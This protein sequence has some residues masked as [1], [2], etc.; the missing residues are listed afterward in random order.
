MTFVLKVV[1]RIFEIIMS[2]ENYSTFPDYEIKG[3][4]IYYC[5]LIVINFY[6]LKNHTKISKSSNGYFCTA[7]RRCKIS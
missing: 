5:T 7:C 6:N 2:G 3:Y 1:K 4:I